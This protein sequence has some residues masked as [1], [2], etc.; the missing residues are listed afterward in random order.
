M[1]ESLLGPAVVQDGQ[2][3]EREKERWC[4][5]EEEVKRR[6]RAFEEERCKEKKERKKELEGNKKRKASYVRHLRPPHTHQLS[7]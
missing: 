1:A 7:R 6:E 4:K 5:E 2:E 3:R